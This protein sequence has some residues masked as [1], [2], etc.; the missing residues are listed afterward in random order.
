MYIYEDN[1]IAQVNGGCFTDSNS[2]SARMENRN[3][4]EIQTQKQHINNKEGIK[5]AYK[6]GHT[7]WNKG[8]HIWANKP[9]PMKGKHHSKEHKQK[10]S[11]ALKGRPA[12]WIKSGKPDPLTYRKYEPLSEEHKKKIGEGNKGKKQSRECKRKIGLANKGR[13]PWNTGKK[14][15]PR[16]KEWGKKLSEANKGKKI[17]KQ[18]RKKQSVAM[19]KWHKTHISAWKGKHFSKEHRKKLSESGKGRKL[20]KE[21]KRKLS[22][23]MIK[24]NAAHIQ[25]F[26]RNP[27]KPQVELY[28]YIKQIYPTAILNY[29][30]KLWKR[31]WYSLDVAV[32][33]LKINFEYDCEYWHKLN[34]KERDLFRDENL[35]ERGWCVVRIKEKKELEM[36]KNGNSG[37]FNKL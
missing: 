31:K 3:T 21:H 28:N 20:T 29:P 23:F 14:R 16:S 13:L 9:P 2:Q 33:E 27:S 24:G 25:S 30:I 17:S 36:V 5:M 26:I 18:T 12:W 19:K 32:P 6:K 22:E 37:N 4:T 8:K 35:I 7:P 15:P 1:E 11:K 10:I 34:G